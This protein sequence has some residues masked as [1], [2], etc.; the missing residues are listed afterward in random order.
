MTTIGVDLGGTKTLVA[1]FGVAH[2][3][4][5]QEVVPTDPGRGSAAVLANIVAT[6]ERFD[7][8]YGRAAAVG[9]GF[10]GLVDGQRGIVDSSVVVP[11]FD[12]LPLASMLERALARPVLLENDATAAGYGEFVALGRRLDLDLLV[13]TIGTGIGGAVVLGGRVHRGASGVA[14]EFG[15]MTV[16]WC[17]EAHASGNRGCLNTLA[18]GR[19]IA[20]YA[21]T[22]AEGHGGRLAGLGALR[23]EQ[24]VAAARAGDASAMAAIARG[25]AALGAGLANLVMAFN[26]HRISL[27]GGVL[28]IGDDFL[29]AVRAAMQPRIFPLA[30]RVL[31]VDRCVRGELTGAL[32]AAVLAQEAF[33]S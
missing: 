19:A 5:A 30:A 9:V 7:E 26:P 22:L 16:D 24:V 32:G 3:L 27:M 23:L 13:A 17:A 33:A 25:A 20:A 4:V 18:S 21:A 2:E 8:R 10:A 12:G 29:A 11:G 31:T 15:N 6:V 1:R 28:Q 14:G